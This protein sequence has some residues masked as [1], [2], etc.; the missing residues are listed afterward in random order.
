MKCI[1][2]TIDLNVGKQKLLQME[3]VKR[4]SGIQ[5]TKKVFSPSWNEIIFDDGEEWIVLYASESARGFRWRKA[6]IDSDI[7]KDI[8]ENVVFPTGALYKLEEP[9]Y[10]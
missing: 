7:P 1:I 4:F 10:F 8:L 6:W 5:T 2:W 3:K 9:E